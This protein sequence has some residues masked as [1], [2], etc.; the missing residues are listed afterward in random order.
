MI[1]E[2]VDAEFAVGEEEVLHRPALVP[3]LLL[4][5]PDQFRHFGN[6]RGILHIVRLYVGMFLFELGDVEFALVEENGAAVAV[7]SFPE[8]GLV[9][10]SENQ[11][12][13]R[14]RAAAEHAGDGGHLGSRHVAGGVRRG[15]VVEER[16][17][18]GVRERGMDGRCGGGGGGGGHGGVDESENECQCEEGNEKE[19]P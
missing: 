12:V 3:D 7:Q 17:D 11:E 1:R 18:G 2:V 15:G 8:Q 6:F 14:R 13:T 5:R 9:G 16:F 10:Q 4:R 19:K